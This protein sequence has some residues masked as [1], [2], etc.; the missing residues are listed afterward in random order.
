MHQSS[1]PSLSQ[2]IWPR[3][4]SRQFLSLSIVQTLLSVTFGYSLSSEA[5]VMRQLRRW[6]RVWR[7]SLTRSHK[8]TS[9]ELSRSCWNGTSALRP[10][11]VLSFMSLLSIKVPK[12]KKS[13]NLF[14][15][16]R[17]Y[18][19]KRNYIFIKITCIKFKKCARAWERKYFK[20]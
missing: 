3:R 14:N 6:K 11:G 1:T 4:D 15:D 16:P 20:Q 17:V 9:M 13:G 19:I 10:D 18:E 12:W 2:A 7:R 5:V 8:R